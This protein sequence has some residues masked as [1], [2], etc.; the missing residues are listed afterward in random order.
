V[1]LTLR[2]HARKLSFVTA[3]ARAGDALDLDWQALADPQATLAIYMGRGMARIISRQLCAAGLSP[4]TPAMVI[5]N[6][7]LPNERIVHTRLDLLELAVP[8]KTGGPTIM[9]VGQAVAV[10][11]ADVES[12]SLPRKRP[13]PLPLSESEHP[14]IKS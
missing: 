4:S 3:H 2:G 14:I 9:L 5:E 11:S 8:P 13:S 12:H 10:K 7:S 6:V 1:S